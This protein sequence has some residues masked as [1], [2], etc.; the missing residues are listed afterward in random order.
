MWPCRQVRQPLRI[1]FI[2]VLSGVWILPICRMHQYPTHNVV[3]GMQRIMAYTNSCGVQKWMTC[4]SLPVQTGYLNNRSASPLTSYLRGHA[5]ADDNDPTPDT[6]HLHDCHGQ[7]WWHADVKDDKK[8]HKKI[9]INSEKL[10]LFLSTIFAKGTT[11]FWI[12]VQVFCPFFKFVVML[13]P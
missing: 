13:K 1:Q 3:C 7:R 2:P 8:I 10:S 4:R 5:S 9:S 6:G 11:N 12:S